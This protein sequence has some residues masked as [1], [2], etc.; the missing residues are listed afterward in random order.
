MLTALPLL[1]G[2]ALASSAHAQESGIWPTGGSADGS[3]GAQASPFGAP[4]AQGSV[5]PP[6]GASPFGAPA[7]QPQPGLQ[8]QPAQPSLAQDLRG[9]PVKVPAGRASEEEERDA[10]LIEQNNL[11]GSTGLLRTSYAGSGAPGTFRLSF[12]ADWFTTNGFLCDPKSKTPEGRARICNASGKEDSASHVGAFFGL[13]VTPLS[14]LEAYASI[15]TYANGNDQ[16]KPDLLQVLGDTTFGVKAFLPPRLG[17]IFTF[18]GEAQLHLLN[19]SGSVGPSGGGTSATFKALGSADFR[20]PEGHGAPLRL[21]LNAGYR[22]DNSGA[23]V[24]DVETARATNSG[25]PNGLTRIPISRI[26]RFGLGI[27]KVDFFQLAL[28]VE[29]PLR[30]VQPYLEYS[31]DIPVNRQDYVC[32]TSSVSPGDECLGLDNFAASD[33]QNQGGPGYKAIPSRLSVGARVQP[34]EDNFRGLS[35]HVALDIGTSG[36]STFIEEVAPQAPWTLYLGVSYAFD[37]KKKPPVERLVTGPTKLVEAPQSF[38]RGF[39]H[40]VNTTTPVVDA[41]A[42]A[43]NGVSPVA[44]DATGRFITHNLPAGQYTFDLK[45]PGYK[46]G[47]CTATVTAAAPV[48]TSAPAPQGQPGQFTPPAPPPAGPTYTDIDCPLEALPRLG[49]VSGTIKDATSGAPVA[50]ATAVLIDAQNKTSSVPAGAAGDFTFSDI[51]PGTATLRVEAPDYMVHT[52]QVEIRANEQAQAS[53]SLNKRPKQ[54]SVKIVG[55]E[56]K[57]SKQIH[58]ETDS[59]KIV[60]DSNALLEE[61]ADILQRTPGLKRVEIQG[62]TDNTGSRDRNAT[63]SQERADAVRSWLMRAGVDGSRLA[64]KGYGQEKPIVPNITAAN[65]ARNRRVQ[66]IIL[67]K[68]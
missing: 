24:E 12:L 41:I 39:V 54:A 1:A 36:T 37:T 63:L 34:F 42:T 16:G 49:G 61:I 27:N 21:N 60:G 50:G 46:P 7:P 26:E 57:L 40:E 68:Q 64:A 19:G 47:T 15:R 43:P 30:K 51:N 4:A 66:F 22:L 17:Q 25:N 52:Q 10:S 65:R 3:V 53:V 44:T 35:G 48:I 18:G 9:E 2:L 62:H 5:T 14:F 45:A 56:I 29:V 67:E 32:H 59:A 31:V 8:P 28:G 55:Q 13:S 23:I 11:Q 33:P 58:F 38:V 6:P 20:K